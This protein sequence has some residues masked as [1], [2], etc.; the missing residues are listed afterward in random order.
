LEEVVG[1]ETFSS[2]ES[3]WA[4]VAGVGITSG[5]LGGGLYLPVQGEVDVRCR[6]VWRTLKR[7]TRG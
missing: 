7:R 6:K 3:K 4:K 2:D 1:F 5:D